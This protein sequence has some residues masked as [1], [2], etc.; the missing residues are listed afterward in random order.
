MCQH[1]AQG[2]S[3][4][5]CSPSCCL[6]TGAP[7][8]SPPLRFACCACCACRA[9]RQSDNT[10]LLRA[11]H[12]GY[13]LYSDDIC[14]LARV[15]Y[16][17]LFDTCDWSRESASGLPGVACGGVVLFVVWGGVCCRPGGRAGST[18]RG[19]LAPAAARAAG[20]CQFKRRRQG[21]SLARP[22]CSHV[23]PPPLHRLPGQS[24]HVQARGSLVRG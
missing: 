17:P 23:S 9:S 7:P 16:A 3:G 15:P 5:R 6:L 13:W 12:H 10:A 2:S 20:D 4:P 18:H 21:P 24:S 8:P 11:F 19:R 1:R 22:P 14:S